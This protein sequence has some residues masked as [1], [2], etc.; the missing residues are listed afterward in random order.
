MGGDGQCTG[1]SLWAT[2]CSGRMRLDTAFRM[3]ESCGFAMLTVP[4]VDPLTKAWQKE[5]FCTELLML[6]CFFYC[7]GP[8]CCFIF[9]DCVE[10]FS[11]LKGHKD[12]IFCVS[13]HMSFFDSSCCTRSEASVDNNNK[14][15]KKEE[16]SLDF[17][18]TFNITTRY[19]FGVFNRFKQISSHS[20]I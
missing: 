17:T 6:F 4:L 12:H 1:R 19:E 7:H 16:I 5:K 13:T 2:C 10:G 11:N 18:S 3:M 20:R 15:V 14:I 8:H 9:G